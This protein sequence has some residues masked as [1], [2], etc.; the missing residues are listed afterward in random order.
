MFDEYFQ[1]EQLFKSPV[2]VADPHLGHTALAAGTKMRSRHSKPIDIPPFS[3][4]MQE[5]ISHIWRAFYKS[6][7]V[8]YWEDK[9]M[10][11]RRE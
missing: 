4:H 8:P 10:G 9:E 7:S 5:W 1:D 6:K 2:Y 11:K 3:C